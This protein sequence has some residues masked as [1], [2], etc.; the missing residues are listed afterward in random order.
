M[1]VK[2]WARIHLTLAL[3]PT[4]SIVLTLVTNC[5]SLALFNGPK[6]IFQTF[7]VNYIT[8][9]SGLVTPEDE[10]LMLKHVSCMII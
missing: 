10:H 7:Q 5:L 8:F 1:Y 3:Q 9:L 4:I 6:I 2:E